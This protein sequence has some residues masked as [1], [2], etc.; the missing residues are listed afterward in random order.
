MKFMSIFKKGNLSTDI[1]ALGLQGG[2][3]ICKNITDKKLIEKIN[4]D[5]G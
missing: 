3:E 5:G 1:Q 4:D 2:N